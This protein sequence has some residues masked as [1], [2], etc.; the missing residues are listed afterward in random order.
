M[1]LDYRRTYWLLFLGVGL[2]FLV[3]SGLVLAAGEPLDLTATVSSLA[4]V[5]IVVASLFGLRDPER[6][7]G[8]QGP[9]LLFFVALVAFLL[10]LGSVVLQVLSL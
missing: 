2:L 10:L 8:P 1:D 9:T 6:V 5:A 4:A 3:Q 7:G